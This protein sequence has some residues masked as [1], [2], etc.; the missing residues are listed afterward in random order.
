MH[1]NP[2]MCTLMVRAN[3]TCH[4]NRV[5]RRWLVLNTWHWFGFLTYATKFKSFLGWIVCNVSYLVICSINGY[6]ECFIR[7]RSKKLEYASLMLSKLPACI[8]AQ[9]TH[10]KAYEPII[11]SCFNV[12][13][14]NNNLLLLNDAIA[15]SN[16]VKNHERISLCFD[17]SY[18]CL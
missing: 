14:F 10:A 7:R 6:N 3:L 17:T 8:I 5:S 1:H 15:W 11:G 12:I 16:R 9:Y 18:R 4:F 2:M 13:T